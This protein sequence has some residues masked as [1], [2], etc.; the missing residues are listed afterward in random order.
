MNL[1]YLHVVHSVQRSFYQFLGRL[2]DRGVPERLSLDDASLGQYVLRQCVPWTICP[3]TMCPLDEVTLPEVYVY[4][5]C[6]SYRRRVI[7]ITIRRKLSCTANNFGLLY[8][9]KRISKLVPK[10][11]LYISKV[12]HDILSGTT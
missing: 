11:H 12:I 9:R 6:T 4:R 7:T 10:F 2:T 1:G 5:P 3:W 8:S